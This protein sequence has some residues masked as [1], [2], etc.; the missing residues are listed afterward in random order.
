MG[1]LVDMIAA[2]KRKSAIAAIVCTL[3]IAGALAIGAGDPDHTNPFGTV[4]AMWISRPASGG[5]AHSETA[6]CGR[7]I[8]E[9]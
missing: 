7:S 6:G 3:S 2:Y 4:H 9:R 8:C 1:R 5:G